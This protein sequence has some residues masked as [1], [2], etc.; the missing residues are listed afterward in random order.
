MVTWDCE[1]AS[2]RGTCAHF[3]DIPASWSFPQIFL[4]VQF[5]RMLPQDQFGGKL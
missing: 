4:F 3:G 2:L 1:Q 5:V